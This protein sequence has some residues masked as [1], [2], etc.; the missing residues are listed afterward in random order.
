MPQDPRTL[1]TADTVRADLASLGRDTA[2]VDAVVQ[3]MALA[4][5]LGRHP[6]DLSGGE[7]QRA[8]LAKVLLM[9]PRVLLL[10][11][12]TKG[13]DGAFKAEFGALLRR[14]CAQGTAVCIVSHDVEFCAQYAD[15]C[16]LLFR[17]EVV[18]E[19]DPRTFFSGNYFYTTAAARIARTA[20]PGAVLCEEVV[21]C[22]AD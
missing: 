13:M 18:T 16:G 21:Q 8:A 4:P 17:G 10:D 20:A 5:L 7:Q 14:L 19:S 6:F 12:P 22:L 1:F 2:L 3:Q 11:E 15:R 9:Q